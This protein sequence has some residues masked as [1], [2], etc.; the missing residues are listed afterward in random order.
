MG[1][2]QKINFEVVVGEPSSLPLFYK[3]IL[4][5]LDN[6]FYSK[7]HLEETLKGSSKFFKISLRI[8]DSLN[9]VIYR[10]GKNILITNDFSLGKEETLWLYRRKD[11]VES[12]FDGLKNELRDKRLRVHTLQAVEGRLFLSFLSLILHAALTK[13]MRVKQLFKN[14]TITELLYE[15]GKIKIVEMENGRT[16]LTETL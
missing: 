11:L 4:F 8:E 1:I 10:L 13:I 3:E 5:V 15:L 16:Y 9:R 12:L 14:Y 7:E 2:Q 6:G